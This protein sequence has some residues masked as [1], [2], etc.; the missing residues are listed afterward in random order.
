MFLLQE[1]SVTALSGLVIRHASPCAQQPVAC[2]LPGRSTGSSPRS[3]ECSASL[4]TLP[5]S[6]PLG[7]PSSGKRKQAATQS[8]REDW[9][10]FADRNARSGTL[11]QG[12]ANAG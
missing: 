5:F 6:C 4:L 12:P 8:E 1:L 3:S 7:A 2:P 10:M 11:T 9:L